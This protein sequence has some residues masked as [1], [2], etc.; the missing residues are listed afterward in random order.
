MPVDEGRWCWCAPT[1]AELHLFD[2]AMFANLTLQVYV[3]LQAGGL[4]GGC[5]Q[6]LLVPCSPGEPSRSTQ[7]L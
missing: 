4:P 3:R 5:W 1:A 2:T 7:L 6:V